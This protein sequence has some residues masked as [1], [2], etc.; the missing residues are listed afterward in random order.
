MIALIE[1]QMEEQV[2][3]TSSNQKKSEYNPEALNLDEDDSTELGIKS[4]NSEPV[5]PLEPDYP[6]SHQASTSRCGPRN[7]RPT[8]GTL[9]VC[10]ASVLK[11]WANELTDKVTEAGRLSVLVYHGGARTRNPEDLTR[12]DVVVTTYTIVTNE[13]PKQ[14]MKD[15]NNDDD[16]E[17]KKLERHGVSPEFAP[18]SK[19]RKPLASNKKRKGKKAK[20]S[21]LDSLDAGPLSRVRWFRVVLDEAQTIKNHRTHVARACSGLRA[22]RRWCLSGTPI[23]NSIDDL[24][25]YFRFLKYEPY[26]VY[27]SFASGIKHLISRDSSHGYKKLQAVLKTLLLRR[28]KGMQIFFI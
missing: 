8:A 5:D 9:V 15:A 28:S 2:E 17:Q 22:K 4:N 18:N 16:P 11:Q 21:D 3:Y 13:V 25:S 19:K 10:P 12:Y 26:S 23:Q 27:S 14:N 20:D 24:Y 7:T 6:P 1:K